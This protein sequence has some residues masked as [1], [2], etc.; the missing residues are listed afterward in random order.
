MRGSI[1]AA[2]ALCL[3]WPAAASAAGHQKEC[4]RITRQIAYYEGVVDQAQ[5]RGN[6][7]WER[8]TRDQIDRLDERRTSL[9]PEYAH[10]TLVVDMREVVKT[11]G[12]IALKVFTFGTY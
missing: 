10:K 4:R 1:P 6:E 12:E 7:L 9:C 11:A 8:A 5:E 3:L 2:L